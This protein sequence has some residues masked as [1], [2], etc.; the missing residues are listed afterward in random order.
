VSTDQ[1]PEIKVS[2]RT[3]TV[4]W[5]DLFVEGQ[6]ARS[7]GLFCFLMSRPPGWVAR[8]NHLQ[9]VFKEGR[10]A[11]AG[12][13]QEC[14]ELGQ[15]SKETYFEG[16]L[17]RQRIVLDEDVL[18]DNPRVRSR[19]SARE[20][21]SQGPGTP[22]PESPAPDA[23]GPEDPPLITTEGTTTEVP[24][25]E[26]INNHEPAAAASPDAEVVDIDS[27]VE[28]HPDVQAV[29]DTARSV[30]TAYMDWW[31]VNRGMPRTAKLPDGTRDFMKLVGARKQPT[32]C[33]YVTLALLNHYTRDQ[34]ATALANWAQG[35]HNGGRKPQ[36]L[37]PSTGAW[38]EALAAV[39][40]GRDPA[41][42]P[43]R[44][45]PANVRSAPNADEALQRAKQRVVH[46][47]V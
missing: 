36:G 43:V 41:Q 24:T 27:K 42:H 15:L 22:V 25:T 19:R 13:M 12:A 35:K 2:R 45:A 40:S 7:W 38:T 33:Q 18:N 44:P 17:R 10:D 1:G 30:V 11:I 8:A 4:I 29:Y 3:Y 14:V 5:D 31:K 39:V 6:S 23:P 20:T 32:N 26:A 16:N 34:I 37:V 9:T 47:N 46:V 28:R 21:D